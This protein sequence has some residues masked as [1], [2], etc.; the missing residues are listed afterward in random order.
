MAERQFD[1]SMSVFGHLSGLEDLLKQYLFQ[2]RF[3]FEKNTELANILDVDELMIRARQVTLPAKSFNELETNYMGTKLLYPGRATVSGS[4]TIQ[5]DEFQDMT[6]SEQLHKWANMLMNQGFKD[7]IGGGSNEM[8][9]GAISNYAAHY[10]ATIEVKIFKSTLKEPVPF[11]WILYRCWPKN[12]SDFQL[13]HNGDSKVTRQAE[14]SYSNFE[15]VR[16]DV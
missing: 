4:T 7:D 8:T 5:W 6:I 16:T 15:I 11:K 13:D 3:I 12:I 9:G 1:P 2:V 14:F 10:C